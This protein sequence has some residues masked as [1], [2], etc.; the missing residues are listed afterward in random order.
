MDDWRG[1][2]ALVTGAADGIGFALCEALVARG[3]RV[4][5]SDV[6]AERLKERAASLGAACAPCDVSDAAAVDELVS[7][8]WSELGPLDLLCANAGVIVPGSILDAKQADIDLVLGVNVWGVVHACRAFVRRMR[9]TGRGGEMLLTGSEHSLSNP[10][11]LRSVPMHLYNLSKHAVLSI[12]DSLR[13]ELEPEGIRVSV[14]CPGPVVSGLLENSNAYRAS[15]GGGTKRD[16]SSPDLSDVDTERLAKLY[17][18]ASRAAEI[19]LAGLRAGAFVIPTHAFEL[20]DAEARFRDVRA[21]FELL[22]PS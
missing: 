16:P 21:G 18:P 9:E 12:G 22:G 1:R 3:A 4:F 20:E 10:A 5:M 19:A 15:R 2:T 14:L 6:A 17:M 8:A 11:Y 7:R 13:A